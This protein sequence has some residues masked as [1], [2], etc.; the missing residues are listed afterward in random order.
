[1][2]TTGDYVM[3]SVFTLPTTAVTD[4]T[5]DWTFQDYM[6]GDS[7]TWYVYVNGTAVASADLPDCGGCGTY[8]TVT[9][10]VDFGAIAPVAGGY[11]I[12]L[13]LQN[14]IAGGNGSVA[15][16]DGGITGLS[17][18]SA[19]PEPGSMAL[20]GLGLLTFAGMLRRKMRQH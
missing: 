2:W 15:W 19:I 13:I 1:M 5:A 18:A 11:Q 16:T 4:L 14:T 6:N 3:S 7:E 12:E 8:E 9:G 20:M 10:T 17:Y